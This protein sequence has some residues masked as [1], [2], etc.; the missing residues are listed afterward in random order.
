MFEFECKDIQMLSVF[1][2]VNFLMVSTIFL[3]WVLNEKF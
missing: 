2:P 3:F 1:F